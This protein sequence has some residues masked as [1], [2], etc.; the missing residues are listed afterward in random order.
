ML[1]EVI[2]MR[3]HTFVHPRAIDV[4]G[5]NSRVE[6]AQAQATLQQRRN[7]DLMLAGVTLESPE[8]ILVS[9]ECRIGPDSHLQP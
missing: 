3:V 6:L 8:T 5:V 1:Y 9:S 4:L 2:T 7:R